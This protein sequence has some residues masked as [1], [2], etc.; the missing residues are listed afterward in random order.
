MPAKLHPIGR[1]HSRILSQLVFS[2]KSSHAVLQT[3]RGDRSP[4]SNAARAQPSY[5]PQGTQLGYAQV[6]DYTKVPESRCIQTAPE[7]AEPPRS[8]EGQKEHLASDTSR[9]VTTR[10]WAAIAPHHTLRAAPRLSPMYMDEEGGGRSFPSRDL[11]AMAHAGLQRVFASLLI[12]TVE[13]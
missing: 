4:N 2:E 1:G 8:T 7:I 10:A 6:L 12:P 3:R 9:R 13:D 11:G 5:T